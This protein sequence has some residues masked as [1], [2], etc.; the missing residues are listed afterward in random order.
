MP[1][2]TDVDGIWGLDSAELERVALE[3]AGVLD[4][5]WGGGFSCPVDTPIIPGCPEWGTRVIGTGGM[6]NCGTI[7][8]RGLTPRTRALLRQGKITSLVHYGV[9]REVAIV[10]VSMQ[11]GMEIEV[12]LQAAAAVPAVIKRGVFQGSSHVGF[13]TWIGEGE[14]EDLTFPRKEAAAAI[15]A[16]VAKRRGVKIPVSAPPPPK[17]WE[18]VWPPLTPAQEAERESHVAAVKAAAELVI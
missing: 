12:A 2:F 14:V 18:Y 11:W 17:P 1:Q 16:E 13:A 9:P 15:S 4:V 5:V 7:V 10:A 8:L 3:Q 6:G